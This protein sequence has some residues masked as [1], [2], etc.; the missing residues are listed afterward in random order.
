MGGTLILGAAITLGK[1]AYTMP[2]CGFDVLE[3]QAAA[4]D[5]QIFSPAPGASASPL[6]KIR[7]TVDLVHGAL[8]R[9]YPDITRETV[10]KDITVDTAPHLL[11]LA[12]SQ[13]LP[14]TPAAL[15]APGQEGEG[16]ATLGESP[17]AVTA[18]P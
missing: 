17:G 14:P 9:N 6:A 13:S 7:L 11:A 2:P 5:A 10:A 12:I 3:A 16:A 18:R 1:V 4:L 8:R 15:V